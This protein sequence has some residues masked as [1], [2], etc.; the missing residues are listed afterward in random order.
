MSGIHWTGTAHTFSKPRVT[1]NL[2][3][4]IMYATCSHHI[5]QY[6]FHFFPRQEKLQ[7]EFGVTVFKSRAL[8]V[9]GDETAVPD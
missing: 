7:A 1:I 3:K 5:D 4:R 9:K 6:T 8:I 2:H